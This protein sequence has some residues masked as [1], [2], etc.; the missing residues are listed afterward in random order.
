MKMMH[1]EVGIYRRY[2]L[3]KE[4]C[5]FKEKLRRDTLDIQIQNL[6]HKQDL[7]TIQK[8]NKGIP[9]IDF[10]K[11]SLIEHFVWDMRGCPKM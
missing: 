1:K 8:R 3:Y 11:T 4:M 10:K 2:G 7:C 5:I 6:V 9:Y